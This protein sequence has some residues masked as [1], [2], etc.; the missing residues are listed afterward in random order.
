MTRLA[1]KNMYLAPAFA[2]E[3]AVPPVP[4]DRWLVRMA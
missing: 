2:E 3:T 1:V 4:P